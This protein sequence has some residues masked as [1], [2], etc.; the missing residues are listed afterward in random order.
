QRQF[1]RQLQAESLDGGCSGSVRTIKPPMATNT[2]SAMRPMARLCVRSLTSPPK[3]GPTNPPML[4][5]E[6][7]SAMPASAPVPCTNAEL[8][9]QIGPKIDASPIIAIVSDASAPGRLL[10]NAVATNP[11]QLMNA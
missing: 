4:P 1:H 8:S 9:D 3:Y 7:M 11:A 5:T 6:L 2:P 10:T